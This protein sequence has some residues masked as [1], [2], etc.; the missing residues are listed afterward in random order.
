MADKNVNIA[1]SRLGDN[2]KDKRQSIFISST[3]KANNKTSIAVNRKFL[4]DSR[5]FNYDTVSNVLYDK[6]YTEDGEDI[7]IGDS[8]GIGIY[9]L[10]D[11]KDYVF[12]EDYNATTFNSN[13]RPKQISQD[14]YFP[15]KINTSLIKD[16]SFNQALL[17]QYERYVSKDQDNECLGYCISKVFPHLSQQYKSLRLFTNSLNVTLKQLPIIAEK[18]NIR[19]IKKYWV[20]KDKKVREK[21]YP[22]FKENP[23]NLPIL[24]ICSL[25]NH[26][27]LDERTL[28]TKNKL[29]HIF[30]GKKLINK[31]NEKPLKSYLFMNYLIKNN[32]LSPLSKDELFKFAI[33]QDSDLKI[34]GSDPS[35]LDGSDNYEDFDRYKQY[36]ILPPTTLKQSAINNDTQA[37]VLI[38]A[39]FETYPNADG[40]V[41]YM[42]ICHNEFMNERKCFEGDDCAEQFL[43]YISSVVNQTL[44]LKPKVFVIFHNL[45]YD[46]TFFVGCK[47][48]SFTNR[49]GNST[50]NTKKVTC[51]YYGKKFF[52]LDSYAFLM[53]PLKDFSENLSL[54]ENTQ[55]DIFPHDIVTPTMI[56]NNK[57][58]VKMALKSK[59]V[60]N[61]QEFLEIIDKYLIKQ[62][63]NIRTS[64]EPRYFKIRDLAY[65]YC[66]KDVEILRKGFKV[67]RE[68]IYNLSN[69]HLDILDFCS[70]PGLALAFPVIEDLLSNVPYLTGVCRQ[71]IQQTIVGGRVCTNKNISH[72]INTQLSDSD[73]SS[74]YPFAYT[75]LEIPSGSPIQ[76]PSNEQI[77]HDTA[78]LDGLYHWYFIEVEILEVRRPRAIPSLS[79]MTKDKRVWEDKPGVYFLNHVQLQDLC[80]F[81]DISYICKGGVGWLKGVGQLHN[82]KDFTND[83]YNE[84]IKIS[85][86]KGKEAKALIIKLLLNSIYGRTL[87]SPIT[88][89]EKVFSDIDG[90]SK[91]S[92]ESFIEKHFDKIKEINYFTSRDGT[93]QCA[94]ISMMKAVYDHSS[95]N[96][97]ASVI[98]AQ[99]KRV[100]NKA[101]Y[102]LD[103]LGYDVYYTD[104]DSMFYPEEANKP[105]EEAYIAKYGESPFAR[106]VL[107]KF[108]SDYEKSLPPGATNIRASGAIFV[109]KKLYTVKLTYDLDDQKD[110]EYYVVKV[111]G[112]PQQAIDY[113]L[114]KTKQNP[115]QMMERLINKEVIK[116]DLR[117]GGDKV[118]F[119]VEKDFKFKSLTD[120]TREV[121]IL[122]EDERKQIKKNKK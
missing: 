57:C 64:T 35:I 88:T 109:A 39:D 70:L 84:R 4:E 118:C 107:G 43:N 11:N 73:I 114:N 111:K 89:T 61:E 108:M 31:S 87:M 113:Y 93:Q 6:F 15:H 96:Q 30:F 29:D 41:A 23:L 13:F 81:Q 94:N 9:N 17:D 99:S 20:G 25:E 55:K 49:I 44:Y 91:K 24:K 104:T 76:I 2:Y 28:F 65:E 116:F 47:G 10:V 22:S 26:C 19:I 119:Q 115:F 1:T 75:K 60:P 103:D 63:Y 16:D 101:V 62:E 95:Y 69:S 82:W 5:K 7:S 80:E 112:I 74:L 14:G 85:K 27:F 46:F 83:L 12:L 40:H 117:C 121:S 86:T 48:F 58:Q 97:V 42:L 90:Y 53:F 36:D 98:L 51:S 79:V 50:K 110:L 66:C 56:T 72:L 59:N 100:M 78:F 68:E 34:S 120:F 67:F 3:D 102:L 71:F 122:D 33:A 52:L 8:L 106:K 92:F 38:F 21:A 54:G 45:G 32:L 105:F 77:Y 18:L 37:K